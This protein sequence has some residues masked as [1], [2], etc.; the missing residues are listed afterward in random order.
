MPITIYNSLTRNKDPFEPLHQPDVNM[1][2]CGVTV[3][4]DCHI[5]HA[6]S[7]YI[8]EV[9]RR[10]LAYRGFKV[11][12]VRNI[13]D[14][15]DKIINR[16]NE[17]KVNW[18]DLVRKYID[19]YYRDLALLGI[20]K[21]DYEPRATDNIKEMVI[22]IGELVNKGY[23]YVTKSGVYFNVRRFPNYGKL[24]GQS[25]DQMESGARIEPQEEKK[26][27][28]DFALWKASKEGE[29][30]WDSPWGKGRPGWHIECSVMSQKFLKTD[31]LD[32]HAGGRDL[33]FPHHENE[34]AQAEALTGKPF[35]KY[36]THHGLLTINGQKMSKSL[37]NFVTIKD[38]INK[39]HED[40]LK[41]FF[42]SAHYSSPLDHSEKKMVEETK[43]FKSF[44]YLFKYYEEHTKKEPIG[45]INDADKQEIDGYKAR[46]IEAMDND[47]N[48]PQALAVLEQLSSLAYSL[49]GNF[50][51]EQNLN[52][53]KLAV[54]TIES[55]LKTVFVIDLRKADP[56]KDSRLFL[57]DGGLR[58]TIKFAME[59]WTWA[60]DKAK[61]RAQLKKE[62]KFSEADKIRQELEEK[63]YEILDKK[64]GSFELRHK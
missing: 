6:R 48:F 41:L 30:S 34:I 9:I 18:Q 10:Y 8:F 23:A 42:V 13:T 36:W 54:E 52:K 7:L 35:A 60:K 37:G 38:S 12:F 4:D 47:F 51:L 20:A 44:M 64:D 2:T 50:G 17:L 59:E 21:A 39:Y 28:L 45:L 15:D 49:T 56:V 11:H 55:L 53:F 14:I 16:A 33:I 3:Y 24:S 40:A 27:P 19:S 25:V 5:G 1:Y 26:D 46:F 63:G 22:Y 57:G 58:D 43:R 29:P 31:T 62:K 32:I 61:E